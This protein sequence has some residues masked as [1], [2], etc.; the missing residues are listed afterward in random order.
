[1][2]DGDGHLPADDTGSAGYSPYPAEMYAQFFAFMSLIASDAAARK[3]YAER[4]RLL[5]MHVIDAAQL[6][7]EE[8][9]KFRH[10]KFAVGDRS[11]WHGHAFGLTVDWIYPGAHA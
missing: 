10:P 11:R 6:G 3:S 8:G 9:E 7:V 1:M 4:A 2:V 5:L